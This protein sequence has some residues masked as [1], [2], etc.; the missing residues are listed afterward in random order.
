MNIVIPAAGKGSR[1]SNSGYSLP[2]PLIE[3]DNEPMI[4]KA[5]KSLNIDGRYIF[6][7]QHELHNIENLLREVAPNCVIIYIDYY[8]SGAATSVLLAEK[9]IDNDDELFVVNCDQIMDWNSTEALHNLRKFDAGVVTIDSNDIK[10]SYVDIDEFGKI[11]RFAE[12]KVISNHALTGLHYWKH[13]S[14][15]VSSAKELI[16]TT[17]PEYYIAPTYNLLIQAGKKIGIHKIS[18]SMIHFVGTPQDLKL[19]ES[20]K[21]K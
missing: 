18:E 13:G 17:E 20:R 10:H 6:I 14:D 11:I 19:Y 1:F 5:V 8:T 9:Y 12:K 21:T 7:L 2:K 16:D 15:F 3:I 4:I